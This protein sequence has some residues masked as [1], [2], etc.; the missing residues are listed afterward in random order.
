MVNEFVYQL[1]RAEERADEEEGQCFPPLPLHYAEG[2]YGGRPFNGHM[3]YK[4]QHTDHSDMIQKASGRPFGQP[5]MG[6]ARAL[7]AD[8]H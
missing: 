6:W 2:V 1:R 4:E 7:F 3:R 5:G 8:G